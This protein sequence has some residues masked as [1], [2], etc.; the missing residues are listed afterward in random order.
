M[1]DNSRELL[2]WAASV[3]SRELGNHTTGKV[4]VHLHEGT[5][6]RVQV[7]RTERPPRKA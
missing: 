2:A 1:P 3:I 7:E 5:V 6:Q 4:I